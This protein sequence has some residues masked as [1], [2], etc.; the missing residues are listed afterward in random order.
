M[1]FN[2]IDGEEVDPILLHGWTSL[3]LSFWE[4]CW[5]QIIITLFC[6][7]SFPSDCFSF[8]YMSYL[9][10]LGSSIIEQFDK[11]LLFSVG[12]KKKKKKKRRP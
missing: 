11:V 2:L 3:F 6:L 10:F 12:V 1:F 5:L 7:F 4:F 8:D 9:G